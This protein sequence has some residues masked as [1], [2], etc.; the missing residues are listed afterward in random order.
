MQSNIFSEEN[1]YDIKYYIMFIN[2]N[3]KVSLS[4]LYETV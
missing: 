2:R 1:Y 3:L 4:E